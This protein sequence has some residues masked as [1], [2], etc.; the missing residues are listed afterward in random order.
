MGDF[1]HK[2]IR[3]LLMRILSGIQPSGT[4]HIGNY[5]GM[6]KQCIE[7]Q[8]SGEVFFLLVDFHVLTTTPDPELLRQRMINAA[9]DFLACGL[10]P[11]KAIFFRQS[12]INEI[13]ELAW[14]LSC[15]TPLGLLGRC[16]SYKDKIASGL[17]PNCGLFYYPVLMSADILL[18]KSDTIPVGKDQKQHVEVTRDI[19]QRFNNKYGEVFPLPT[20]KMVENL[21]TIV[22]SDG[23][24]MSKSYDNVIE[25]FGDEKKTRKKIMKIITDSKTSEEPKDPESCSIFALYKLFASNKQVEEMANRYRAGGLM[26]G[27]AKQELYEKYTEYFAP[28]KKRREELVADIGYVEKILSDGAK[29][30][31]A[32]TKKNIAEIRALVGL[33]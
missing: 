22:G 26:Y 3:K 23:R 8:N 14:I 10:D 33:R 31:R 5:F 1:N 29:K 13:T 15:V 2:Y 7:L 4:F 21:A 24:K 11:E 16:H 12:D 25:I 17:T 27:H 20:P 32:I 19:A 30:A 9:I 6:I 18:F 28:M